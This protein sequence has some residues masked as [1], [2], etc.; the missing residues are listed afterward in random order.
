MTSE[1]MAN[2]NARATAHASRRAPRPVADAVS[3]L[4]RLGDREALTFEEG[5]EE[6]ADVRLILDD[7]YGD[8]TVS[9]QVATVLGKWAI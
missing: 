8:V 1:R 3:A 4:V 6:L 7:Q 5:P 9:H 2:A